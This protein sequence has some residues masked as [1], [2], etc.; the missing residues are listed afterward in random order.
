MRRA[1]LDARIEK[2]NCEVMPTRFQDPGN[3]TDIISPSLGGDG[4][5]TGVLKDPI[6]STL[7]FLGESKEIPLF[8]DLGP[9]SRKIPR[10][11]ECCLREI[12]SR[13]FSSLR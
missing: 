5:E 10:E 11:P 13:D 4:A 1:L 7:P 8:V 2:E 12:E 3:C 6:E 9:C